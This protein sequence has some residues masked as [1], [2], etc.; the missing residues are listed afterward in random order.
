MRLLFFLFTL[1]PVIV[2]SQ[3]IF[4]GSFDRSFYVPGF[5]DEIETAIV[6]D[7]H[8]YVGG[9]FTSYNDQIISG[10]AKLD[11]NDWVP[12]ENG[13]NAENFVGG[14][15]SFIV[16]KGKL[17][18]GGLFTYFGD[19]EISN[20]AF[21]DGIKWH[22]VGNG[23]NYQIQELVIYEDDLLAFG[24]FQQSADIKIDRIAKW[25][26]QSWE[27]FN[28]R[29]PSNAGFMSVTAVD[30]LLLISGDFDQIA[31]ISNLDDDSFVGEYQFTQIDT[32]FYRGDSSKWWVLGNGQR[33]FSS[34]IQ[35]GAYSSSGFT[36]GDRFM[37]ICPD[38]HFNC[39]NVWLS[40]SD[41]LDGVEQNV[42]IDPY[43]LKYCDGREH[44]I[45]PS[46]EL[47][48]NFNPSNDSEFIFSIREE[49]YNCI[50]GSDY[51]I[52]F[53][54]EKVSNHNKVKKPFPNSVDNIILW[55]GKAVDRFD[56]LPSDYWVVSTIHNGEIYA[57]NW[58]YIE[59]QV[60]AQ[61]F[62]WTDN[63]WDQIG[64][65]LNGIIRSVKSLNGRLIVVGNF[66]SV[67]AKQIFGIAEWRDGA[68]EQVGNQDH[69]VDVNIV[70]EF[71]DQIFISGK[72]T[73]NARVIQTGFINTQNE[74]SITN[75]LND[76]IGVLGNY[77]Y[78]YQ[79]DETLYYYGSFYQTGLKGY[80]NIAYYNQEEGLASFSSGIGD[81]RYI[82]SDFVSALSIINNKIT[83]AGKGLDAE[84]NNLITFWNGEEWSPIGEEINTGQVIELIEFKDTLYAIGDFRII[85]PV[86]GRSTEWIYD[87]AKLNGEVWQ[88]VNMP[89]EGP[90]AIFDVLINNQKLFVSGQLNYYP[91]I[92]S[93]DGDEWF[94]YPIEGLPRNSS[95][96]NILFFEGLLYASISFQDPTGQNYYNSKI[97]QFRDGNWENV[98]EDFDDL[99][100]FI[101]EHEDHLV[102]SGEFQKNGANKIGPIAIWNGEEWRGLPSEISLSRNFGGRV[103]QM[104]SLDEG[105][106]FSGL[107]KY[108]DDIPTRNVGI[109]ITD[110]SKNYLNK[111]GTE[112]GFK[113]SQNYPNP[114]NP[115]TN[116][117]FTLP[118][119]SVVKID[120]YDMLGRNIQTITNQRYSAGTHTVTFDAGSLASG[121]YLYQLNINGVIETRRMTFLK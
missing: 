13:F 19:E 12:L 63:T 87:I 119:S 74:L 14:I 10:I 42:T 48:G 66:T 16:Y 108:V 11:D 90:K 29:F 30:S 94:R 121:I 27:P 101:I 60:E 77:T 18:A 32:A 39:P 5:D 47:R 71:D 25:N 55:D 95:F 82:G 23:L 103:Y 61:V 56:K 15:N 26:G 91:F 86:E 104:Q 84:N 34:F 109:Y 110:G 83:I 67:D 69:Y 102:V 7:E 49:N 78:A 4:N 106:L 17:F 28:F 54:A 64:G 93:W 36:D 79:H 118:V 24:S 53:L 3:D 2:Q 43:I 21:W 92:S 44:T 117:N 76:G 80:E 107:F 96:D 81:F 33:T 111:N 62:K 97:V 113:L 22:S 99:V 112:G 65:D 115:T 1:F 9:Y 75:N 41:S 38:D 68:W 52:R 8:L 51:E 58:Q 6:F 116:I 40:F 114:F 100:W 120:I 73:E 89:F 31:T 20:I 88:D 70:G 37:Q 35:Q 98:G 57:A 50:E 59:D 72:L 105:I 85:K 45:G 46:L